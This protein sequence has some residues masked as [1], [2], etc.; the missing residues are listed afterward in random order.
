MFT[1][2]ES[3]YE[4]LMFNVLAYTAIQIARIF[5]DAYIPKAWLDPDLKLFHSYAWED[6]GRIYE[7]LFHISRWKDYLPTVSS[8]THFDKTH[9]TSL[10]EDYIKQFI[11]ELNMAESH[12]LRSI[13]TCLVFA[14]WN[15]L[16][17]FLFVF[18]VNVLIHLPF[19]MIQRYNRPRL[20]HILSEVQTRATLASA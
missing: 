12:H 5:Y 11:W 15:P 6:N 4:L 20:R 18:T 13:I 2:L 9:F 3:S 10:D 8:P 1:D 16:D 14:L 19:I 7:R 17:M